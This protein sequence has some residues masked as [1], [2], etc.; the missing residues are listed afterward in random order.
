MQGCR[1]LHWVCR[2]VL[3]VLHLVLL[4]VLQVMMVQ[5]QLGHRHVLQLLQQAAGLGRQQQA[6]VVG[7]P[8]LQQQ[9]QQRQLCLLALLAWLATAALVA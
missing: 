5:K 4:A 3:R 2:I 8:H 6:A 7:A 9:Q 1:G